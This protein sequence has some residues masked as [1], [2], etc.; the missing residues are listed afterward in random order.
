MFDCVYCVELV[1]TFINFYSI[2]HKLSCRFTFFHDTPV[3]IQ[4]RNG[5]RKAIDISTKLNAA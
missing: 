4:P 2:D 1:N 3:H 5:M